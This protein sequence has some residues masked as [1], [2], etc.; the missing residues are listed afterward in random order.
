MQSFEI[1]EDA[2]KIAEISKSLNSDQNSEPE[3]SKNVSETSDTSE[4]SDK[5]E[6]EESAQEIPELPFEFSVK[7]SRDSEKDGLRTVFFAKNRS[8]KYR[9]WKVKNKRSLDAAETVREKRDALVYSCLDSDICLDA[10]EFNYLLVLIRDF[11]DPRPFNYNFRCRKCGEDIDYSVDLTKIYHIKL[12]NFEPIESKGHVFELDHIPSERKDIY[13]SLQDKLKNEN[14]K[15]LNDFAFH[16]VKLDG[17][18]CEPSDVIEILNEFDFLDYAE[19]M[20]KFGRMRFSVDKLNS[21]QCPSCSDSEMFLFDELP[22][23]FPEMFDL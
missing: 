7:D 1:I 5:P 21:V 8:M 9:K 13:E 3:T 6:S 20:I 11:T 12:A 10:E 18:E 17:N 19:M 15:L 16:V 14:D 22:D 4:T 23:F 2:D